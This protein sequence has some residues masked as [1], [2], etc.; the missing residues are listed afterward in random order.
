METAPTKTVILVKNYSDSLYELVVVKET[1][2]CIWY[3]SKRNIERP[4]RYS[5][6]SHYLPGQRIQKNSTYHDVF[7]TIDEAVQHIRQR[8]A[9]RIEGA[10]RSLAR[11]KEE[12][13][14]FDEAAKVLLGE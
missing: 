5:D 13:T 7:D 9:R 14:K 6:E 1:E 2:K 10:E 12:S 8:Y 11:Y 4:E 3:T